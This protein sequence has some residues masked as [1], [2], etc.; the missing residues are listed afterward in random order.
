MRW[1]KQSFIVVLLMAMS[2]SVA[3]AR[4]PAVWFSPDGGSPDLV[5]LFSKPQLW[6]KARGQTDVIKF[7]PGQVN[8]AKASV[9]N[10]FDELQRVDAF[11]K[12]RQWGIDIAIEAPAVKE[13]DCSG[14]GDTKDSRV[15]GDAKGATLSYIKT[16]S[17]AG[18]AVKFIAMDEP[19][20]SGLGA[21]H[22]SIE[23]T[24]AKTAAYAKALLANGNLPTWAPGLA[25]GDIEVYPSKNVDQLKQWTLALERD[26]FKPAFF[27]LDVD[28]HDVEVRGPKLH[29][30]ADLQALKAFFRTEGIPFGII[31][32]SGHDPENSDLSYY[33]HVVDW[34][35]RVHA[36]IG[37]PDQS[38][39]Q[40][41][42]RRSSIKCTAGTRCGPSNNWMCS[43]AD[44]AYCGK[45]SVPIN[46]PESDRAIYSHTRLINDALV[47]L[48]SP[49][50]R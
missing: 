37:K 31:F 19:M 43:S 24:A 2:A 25:I 30:D 38:I 6:T 34:A 22:Q 3:S 4:M 41:W 5:D 44:P 48:K 28:V 21:C 23:E 8:A 17:T 15:R 18:A 16:V 47:I 36:A 33:S 13:W 26:G 39:F 27:H 12:L 45:G 29:F 32:W 11:G 7:G 49:A 1:S 10:G 50:G 20:V 9:T 35:K 46:L 14:V 42:V 40:S